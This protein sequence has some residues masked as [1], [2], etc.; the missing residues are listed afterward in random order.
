MLRLG[1]ATIPKT[2]AGYAL[3]AWLDAINSREATKIQAYVASI[4]STQPV[5]WLVS[6]SEHS[7]GFVLL[8]V[9]SKGASSPFI[10]GRKRTT[11]ALGSLRV[12]D[13][14]HL[15]VLS[16]AIHPLPPGAVVD[17]ITLDASE[18]RRV[19]EGV[20]ATLR[21]NYLYPDVA[22]KMADALLRGE[23]RNNESMETD[24]GAFAFLITNQLRDISHDKHL[25]V[26]YAPFQTRQCVDRHRGFAED[27]R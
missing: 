12:K 5:N 1:Q 20:N 15:A 10:S 13:S 19:I 14:R 24:G 23:R 18:K 17:D 8:S 26:I 4:D 7:G 3:Q 21:E 22:Q 27:Q 2:P 9:T 16:F 6:L 25:D 11:E